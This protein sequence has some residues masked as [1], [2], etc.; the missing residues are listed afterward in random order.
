MVVRLVEAG[1]RGAW[2]EAET[3]EDTKGGASLFVRD[4][5]IDIGGRPG[6][7]RAVEAGLVVEPLEHDGGDPGCGEGSQAFSSDLTEHHVAGG[8]DEA[9][10]PER[11]AEGGRQRLAHRDRE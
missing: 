9:V 4:E 2:F 10:A 3:I 1:G 11:L 8:G 7:S 5:E 6:A